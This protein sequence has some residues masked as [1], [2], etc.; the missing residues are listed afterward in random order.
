MRNILSSHDASI[1]RV[2][3]ALSLAAG[4]LAGTWLA[5][6]SLEAGSP[7]LTGA[8]VL[9]A[10]ILVAGLWMRRPAGS[11]A[12]GLALVSGAMVMAGASLL[13]PEYPELMS[14]LLPVFGGGACGVVVIQGAP[15]CRKRVAVNEAS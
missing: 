2:I 5:K 7:S 14:R 8:W 4:I 11:S 13:L 6:S 12:L 3:A 1:H 15:A 10:A 9:T